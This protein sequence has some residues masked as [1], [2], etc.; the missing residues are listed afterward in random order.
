MPRRYEVFLGAPTPTQLR[1][2]TNKDKGNGHT[3]K[4][5]SRPLAYDAL[6]PPATLA[7]ATRRISS[8]YGNIIWQDDDGE[9]EPF[10][11]DNA[12]AKAQDEAGSKYIP[13]MNHSDGSLYLLQQPHT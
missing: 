8:I 3:W 10:E 13:N 11:D 1:S 9:D 5:L 7:A 12:H 2:S 6:P 4:T